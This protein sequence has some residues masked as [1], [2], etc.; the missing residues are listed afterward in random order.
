[1]HRILHS[2][3]AVLAPLALLA[4]CVSPPPRHGPASAPDIVHLQE[5]IET[6]AGNLFVLRVQD[7]FRVVRCIPDGPISGCWEEVLTVQRD[8]VPWSRWIDVAAVPGLR[9]AFVSPTEVAVS[10]T[11]ETDEA[12]E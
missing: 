10:R 3:L 7:E 2:R 11:G 4:G 5:A 8:E 9:L 12:P 6:D 1:M